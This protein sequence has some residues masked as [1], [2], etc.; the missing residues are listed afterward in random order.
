MSF[1]T[2]SEHN[3]SNQDGMVLAHTHTHK[4]RNIDQLNS[5]KS[6][7]IKSHTYSHLVYNNGGKNL[8]WR[9]DI[10]SISGAGKIG[11]PHVK[12]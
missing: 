12:E 6:P 7:E 5:I 10:S 9:K 2:N 3:C 8:A 11:W 4:N 1:L